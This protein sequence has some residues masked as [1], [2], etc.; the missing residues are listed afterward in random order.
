[1]PHDGGRGSTGEISTLDPHTPGGWTDDSAHRI[2]D[3]RLPC[4]VRPDERDSL[5][6]ADRERDSVDGHGRAV[7]DDHVIEREECQSVADPR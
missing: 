7:P 4:A 2:E 1:L 6:L 5:A 3:R